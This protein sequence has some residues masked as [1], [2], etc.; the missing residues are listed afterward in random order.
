MIKKNNFF[1][2]FFLVIFI[3]GIY[4]FSRLQN[5]TAI[6][7]FGDEAIYIR[8]SQIIKNVETLRF[9][10]QSDG[11][12]PLFMWF[13]AAALKF[14]SDPLV[15]GRLVSVFAG[16]GIMVGIFFTTCILVS[17]SKNEKNPLKFIFSSIKENFYYGI[18]ASIIY[19][20]LPFSFFFDR[21]ALPDNTL[22]FFGIWSIFLSFLLAK[23]RRLDIALI[24]GMIL[25]L[26]WLTK[27]PAI[28]FIALSCLTFVVLNLN[29]L[30]TIYLPL[31]ASLLGFI[32][33]N[34]L[35]LGP[36]FQMIALRNQ[37][38]VWSFSEIL[39]HP[40]NPLKPHLGDTLVI[41]SQ[42]ISWPI[43]IF[44]IIGFI[45]FLFYKKNT[46]YYLLMCWCFLPLLSNCAIAKVFTARYILY[47]LPPL[48][49]L[50]S[51]GISVFFKRPLAKLIFLFVLLIP[52][53][54]WIKNIS[55]SPFNVHLSSTEQGYL[56]DWTSGWGIK[57]SADF[58]KTRA[59]QKNIIVGTEGSF[60]TLPDGLQIY[61]DH[62]NQLTVI[63]LGLG[64]TQIPESLTNAFKYGDEVYILINKSRFTISSLDQEKLKLI[65]SYPK[66]NNDELL[67][68]QLQ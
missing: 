17:F 53:I 58:L 50:I 28:Y 13:T 10:P 62:V 49:I 19:I 20:F 12:E 64:F 29:R 51:L 39:K 18:L 27:S 66:P 52:N 67:L 11:K 14:V 42:Y 2:R 46:Q 26:A 21:M 15:T 3:V 23:F 6:P 55:L 36:Q 32:I 4:F 38:Y 30:K 33:Y 8:W 47:I 45:L 56:R 43:L 9:I 37:D 34:I 25:G 48:I 61:T 1:T 65:K 22:S 31:I 68:Y 59:L 5:L 63:G 60:G 7:V 35:R 24:L 41:F 16:F 57:E 44:A 40:L 54:I